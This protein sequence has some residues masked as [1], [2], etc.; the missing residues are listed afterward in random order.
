MLKELVIELVTK[1]IRTFLT[2]TSTR[3]RLKKPHFVNFPE[4]IKG[5]L[6]I[7]VPVCEQLCVYCPYNRIPYNKDLAKGY[8]KAIIR[9]IKYYSQQLPKIEVTSIYFGGGTPTV[10]S[11]GIEKIIDAL[12]SNFQIAGPLCVETNPGDL[13]REKVNMLKSLEVQAISLGIQ[14]FYQKWLDLIG[15]QYTLE[16]VETVLACVDCQVK[17]THV[18]R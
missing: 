18:F 6:Y 10:L 3:F 13:T 1:S 9:E 16:K 7:H 5:G 8:M 2:G 4:I 17:L 11:K 12:R 15:R 14:S